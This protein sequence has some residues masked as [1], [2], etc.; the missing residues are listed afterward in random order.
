MSSSLLAPTQV[1]ALAFMDA[2]C[3]DM[4]PIAA[5]SG[6]AGTGK[7]VTLAAAMAQRESLGDRIIRIS[8]FVAGPLSLHRVIAHA[9]G[10][11]DAG[12]LSVDELEP[13]LRRA[14]AAT[15]RHEPPILSIDDAQ[16]LLPE[17]LRYLCLLAGLR[18][19]G[20]PLF[21]I[22]LA[23]RPGFTMRQP[24]TVQAT[25]DALHPDAARQTVERM[26]A[27]QG[28]PAADDAVR[29]IVQHA[30]GNLRKI[31]ALVRACAEE[32]QRSG[33]KRLSF[34]MVQVAAGARA[35]S[36]KPRS[37]LRL[38]AWMALPALIAVLVAGYGVM[39]HRWTAERAEQ[40]ATSPP[41]LRHAVASQAVASQAATAT[42]PASPTP[43]LAQATVP[44]PPTPVPATSNPIVA[45]SAP[46]IPPAAMP[47]AS[48][49]AP[50]TSTAPVTAQATPVAPPRYT[51]PAANAP[52]GSDHSPPIMTQ[53]LPAPATQAGPNPAPT[54]QTAQTKP[55]AAPASGPA[56]AAVSPPAVV[57][58]SVAPPRFAASEA[59]V[60]RYRLYNV[61]A[62]HHG[63][64]PRW[65][66]L[67][68]NRQSRTFAGFNPARLGLSQVTVQRLREGNLDLVVDGRIADDGSA[69]R[70]IEAV[71]LV[72]VEPHHGRA[73]RAAPAQESG[74]PAPSS[75]IPDAQSPPPGYLQAPQGAIRLAPP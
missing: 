75:D 56:L 43:R 25:L 41:A 31:E 23:G 27:T 36:R 22:I 74:L 7:S 68:L 32:A 60:T 64:C 2:C 38:Q 58:A 30:Q 20:R 48:A 28:L 66:V 65:A 49:P 21:R 34:D 51:A 47:P 15:G 53:T 1:E 45:R 69:G 57:P 9:L 6:A 67:D 54:A 3:R 12:D 37:R 63:I 55:P 61:G 72:S 18:D 70:R 16:S 11:A 5:L 4:V 39:H 50:V 52:P 46:S 19:G 44:N 17:T 73:P 59:D 8:N 62:C 14:L 26:L 71:R 29:E 24:I 13:V 33:R 10:V 40:A 35:Q 42:S